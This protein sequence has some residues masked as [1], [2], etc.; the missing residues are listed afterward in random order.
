MRPLPAPAPSPAAVDELCRTHTVDQLRAL[1]SQLHVTREELRLEHTAF[2]Y[3]VDSGQI[4]EAQLEAELRISRGAIERYEGVGE[5]LQKT[6]QRAADIEGA[7]DR[8]ETMALR[9]DAARRASRPRSPDLVAARERCLATARDI[10]AR[11]RDLADAM[12]A[13]LD[14]GATLAAILN[15]DRARRV[16]ELGSTSTRFAYGLANLFEADEEVGLHGV[17][18][19]LPLAINAGSVGAKRPLSAV[20]SELVEEL[21]REAEND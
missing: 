13:H 2:R 20:V 9:A 14:A 5:A 7:I 4:T 12:R 11:T 19:L 10:E 21:I 17:K 1:L 16:F 18:V 8:Y 6:A 3:R 15:T